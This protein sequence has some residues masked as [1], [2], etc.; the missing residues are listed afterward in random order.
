MMLDFTPVPL[1]RPQIGMAVILTLLTI[2]GATSCFFGLMHIVSAVRQSLDADRESGRIWSQ[3]WP[4]AV[5]AVRN[6]GAGAKPAD[7]APSVAIAR[8]RCMI[9]QDLAVVVSLKGKDD[10]RAVATAHMATTCRRYFEMMGL[11]TA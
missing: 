2:V 11:P 8:D 10:D 7:P 1:R 5:A 4:D 6:P 3:P 9:A